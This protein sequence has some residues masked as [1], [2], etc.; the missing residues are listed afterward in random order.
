MVCH[1]GLPETPFPPLDLVAPFSFALLAYEKVTRGRT[2]LSFFAF[3]AAL[4]PNK[5]SAFNNFFFFHFLFGG[6][7]VIDD[8]GPLAIA[9]FSPSLA[10]RVPHRL[11]S[12]VHDV[13]QELP[14]ITISPMFLRWFSSRRL[15]TYPPE[16]PLALPNQGCLPGFFFP[17]LWLYVSLRK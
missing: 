12:C 6:F 14:S 17:P 7:F 2:S 10:R 15:I 1:P 5:L 3:R 9:N 11:F 16:L 8:C 13:R 4:F